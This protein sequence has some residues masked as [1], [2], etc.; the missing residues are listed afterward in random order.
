MVGLLLIY[1]LFFRLHL[2]DLGYALLDPRARP[3]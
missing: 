1:F 3:S 2:V